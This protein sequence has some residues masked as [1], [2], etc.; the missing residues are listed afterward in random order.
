MTEEEAKTKW[1]PFARVIATD[2]T[3]SPILNLGA[4]N[5]IAVKAGER[6][7]GMCIASGCMA[8]RWDRGYPSYLDAQNGDI[9]ESLINGHCGIAGK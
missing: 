3:D 7:C 6:S 5:R 1:C 4:Y 2:A 8:W 9:S